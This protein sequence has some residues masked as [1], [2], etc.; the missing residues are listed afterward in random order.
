[1]APDL[2]LCSQY[3]A[4]LDIIIHYLLEALVSMFLQEMSYRFLLRRDMWA[5]KS[6]L[7]KGQN[8]M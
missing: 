4:L 6:E 7:K 1:M 5:C 8:K 3:Y 2:K